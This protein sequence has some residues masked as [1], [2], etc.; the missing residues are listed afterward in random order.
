MEYHCINAGFL[1]NKLPRFKRGKPISEYKWNNSRIIH[2][3]MKETDPNKS[4]SLNGIKLINESS[5]INRVVCKY[6]P[7]YNSQN[8]EIQ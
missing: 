1:A 3:V 4:N 7:V 6:F 5:I 8:R 2:D